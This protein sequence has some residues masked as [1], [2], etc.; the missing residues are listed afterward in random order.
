[1]RRI[2]FEIQ[3][4]TKGNVIPQKGT[5]NGTLFLE[6][7]STMLMPPIHNQN[8]PLDQRN[9]AA[10]NPKNFVIDPA[11]GSEKN[12]VGSDLKVERSA[13]VWERRRHAVPPCHRI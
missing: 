13:I 5:P 10:K 9:S 6:K 4:L 3:I 1:M 11:S 7:T 12:G 8:N 2:L